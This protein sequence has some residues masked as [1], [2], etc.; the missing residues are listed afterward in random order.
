LRA[1]R[2]HAVLLEA[3]PFA[4]TRTLLTQTMG[5]SPMLE[6]EGW[7]LFRMPNGDSWHHCRGPDGR[8]YPINQQ[9]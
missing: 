7:S 1:S 3:E 8:V 9:L 2:G 5:L 4:A 6:M